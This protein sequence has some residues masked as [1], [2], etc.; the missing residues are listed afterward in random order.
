MKYKSNN[1]CAVHY[2]I[3][4]ETLNIYFNFIS[5][6]LDTHSNYLY[7]TCTNLYKLRFFKIFFE[8]VI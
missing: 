6:V 3:I 4:S 1:K 2:N 5:Y 7:F 8:N